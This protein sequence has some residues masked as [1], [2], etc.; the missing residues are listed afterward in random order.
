MK[1]K[2]SLITVVLFA[3]FSTALMAKALSVEVIKA[4]LGLVTSDMLVFNGF[5]YKYKLNEE[6]SLYSYSEFDKPA[7]K[8]KD[9]KPGNVYYFEVTNEDMSGKSKKGGVVRYVSEFPL[10]DK[11]EFDRNEK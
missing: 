11:E 1:I 10:E 3:T 8:L 4:E 9:L 5:K 2:T 6:E 7:V